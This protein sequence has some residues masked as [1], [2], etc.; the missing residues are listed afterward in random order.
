MQSTYSKSEVVKEAV[1]LRKEGLMYAEISEKIGFPKST[2]HGW[3]KKVT[4]KEQQLLKVAERLKA[5]KIAH[6]RVLSQVNKQNKV[7]RDAATAMQAKAVTD[8]I[9]LTNV[10][11]QLICSIFFWCEG[12]KNVSSGVQFINSDPVMVQTF[13]SLL[14]E[15]FDVD[16]SKFR[17]LIHLHEYHDPERQLEYWSS[18][19][20][21]PATQ[22]HKSFLKPHTGKNKHPDYPGCVSIRY[23]DRQFG[24]LLQ[25]IYNNFGNK[26]RGVR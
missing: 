23:L 9:D 1:R 3:L 13:L 19:I 16:E 14:R 4:L 24:L 2:I 20:G 8:N 15:S 18:V 22:F 17:A 25:M 10:N 21:I 6:V 11:K 12:G 7:L 26:Y 5:K